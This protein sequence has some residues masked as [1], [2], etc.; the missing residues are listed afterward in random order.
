MRNLNCNIVRPYYVL[1]A[2]TYVS[3]SII[4]KTKKII[5]KQKATAYK[6]AAIYLHFSSEYRLLICIFSFLIVLFNM[7]V[8]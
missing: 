8:T 3:C 7:S 1:H 5:L 6:L 4:L 2:K